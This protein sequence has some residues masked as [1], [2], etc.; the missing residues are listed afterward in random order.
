VVFLIWLALQ[1][2]GF[3]CNNVQGDRKVTQP[4][5]KYLLTVAIQYNSTGLI[6]TQYRC[7]YTRAHAGHVMLLP[8][9][10]SPSVVFKQSK[11]KDVFFT[12]VTSV[13]CRTL[14]GIS[15]LLNL[16]EKF[17]GYI[18]QFFCV[19]Q[20][21]NICSSEPFPWHWKRAGQKP[22]RSTF[23]VKRRLFGRYPTNFVTLSTKVIEKN[24]LQSGLS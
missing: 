9:R 1:Y 10:A 22:V 19:K 16:P 17:S 18:S 24:S 4:I 23:G 2:W 3:L 11:C 21:Y 12:S 6:N 13:H 14:P 5:L 15:F 7:D 8:A 20:I